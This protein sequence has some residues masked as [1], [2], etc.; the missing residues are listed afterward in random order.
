ML[1]KKEQKR[2][3]ILNNVYS[4]SNIDNIPIRKC[5]L[6]PASDYHEFKS[7]Q[8]HFSYVGLYYE[9]EEIGFLGSEYRALFWLGPK[10]DEYINLLKKAYL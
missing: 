4:S 2:L 8:I 10:P 7:M 9:Y 5:F 6:V 3:E 1:N